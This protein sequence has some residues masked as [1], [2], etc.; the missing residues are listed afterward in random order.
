MREEGKTHSLYGNDHGS[1]NEMVEISDLQ[2][3]ARHPFKVEKDA[4]MYELMESI[5]RDGVLVPLLVR[6]VRKKSGEEEQKIDNE[7]GIE[8]EAK[9]EIISG[10][11]RRMA[12][13]WA[14][15][16]QVPAIIRDLDDSLAVIAMV[17]SNLQ[18]ER[19]LPSEKAYA[20]KMRLEAMKHQG[21][22]CC[23]EP[24]QSS[25]QNVPKTGEPTDAET[26]S[27]QLEPAKGI[28][29]ASKTEEA[30]A[31]IDPKHGMIACSLAEEASSVQNEPNCKGKTYIPI[32][33]NELLARQVG[34]NVNQIKRYIRLTFLI[35]QILQM[36]DDR[37]L[38]MSSAV[39]IS[40]L[41]EK[42]QYE[43]YAVMDIEQTVPTLSQANRM[44]RMSQQKGL[45]MDDIYRILEEPKPNQREQVKIPLDRVRQYFP[46][47]FTPAQQV[48]LIEKLL[49]G[50]ATENLK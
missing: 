19:L 33:S 18:R 26:T 21:R 46:K 13:E 41:R 49:A 38:A 2:E 30:S 11:R 15:L 50:W 16:K 22:R 5:R 20:Y 28:L 36:V 17:D 14:G 48:D 35:P 1:I 47:D 43:P 34:E 42:E 10:H 39:E 4:A 7:K 25:A 31:Q 6:P 37:K 27:V 45:T 29:F 40:F 9:Y 32:R 8:L 44:K 12:A 24:T 23:T 3:F